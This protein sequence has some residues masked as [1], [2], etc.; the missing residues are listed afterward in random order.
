MCSFR[1][2]PIQQHYP[3]RFHLI[4][5]LI[6]LSKSTNTFIPI[7]PLIA[8][9]SDFATPPKTG[10]SLANYFI[11]LTL[12][13]HFHPQP[14]EQIDYKKKLKPSSDSKKLDFHSILKVSKIQVR[15]KEFRDATVKQVYELLQEYLSSVSHA[16]AF[17]ELVFTTTLKVLEV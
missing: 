6:K 17:P 2:V 5:A 11:F 9:V 1:L 13:Y 14:L 15:E 10:S 3:L 12:P 7:L 16:I 4:K 8:R